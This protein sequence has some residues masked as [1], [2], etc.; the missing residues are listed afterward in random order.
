M[1]PRAQ[2]PP[3]TGHIIVAGAG[4]NIGSHL[5][6]LLAR[7]PNVVQLT[8]IDC[9]VYE[10]KN[11]ASQDI[12]PGDF[13]RPK[14]R[15]Q[16]RRARQINPRL[17]VRPIHARLEDVP[18]GLCRGDFI[19]ACLDSKEARRHVNEIAWHLNIPWIDGGVEAGAM[20]ARVNIYQPGLERP[21][22]ECAWDPRDY[23]LLDVRHPCDDGRPQS[24]PTNAPACLGALAA[25]LQAVEISK[26]LTGALDQALIGRQVLIEA[27]TH[28]HFVTWFRHNPRCRFDHQTWKIRPLAESP[29]RLSL[30][31][32][33]RMAGDSPG[34]GFAGKTL[35]TRLDCPR[36]G[37]G[38]PVFKLRH[39]LDARERRCDRCGSELLASAFHTHA[40]LDPATVP[41]GAENLPLASLGLRPGDV[42]S[43]GAGAEETYVELAGLPAS[44][45]NHP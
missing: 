17:H 24:H 15:V 1:K 31:A 13:G 45:G 11:L 2:S 41:H 29:A 20:L 9:D 40:R 27:A 42:I 28:R 12:V 19:V 30:R 18:L 36:C 14:V 8:L 4:G 43:L 35:A 38:R 37:F 23:R 3:N 16:S 39:R 22:A 21:C 34:L 7:D 44:K 33:F 5:V 32:A 25:S 26:L 10:P 6:P